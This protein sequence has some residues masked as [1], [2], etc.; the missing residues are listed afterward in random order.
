[1]QGEG[2]TIRGVQLLCL[3]CHLKDA[4]SAIDRAGIV[5]TYMASRD[6]ER[7]GKVAI[8]TS[9]L[10]DAV[11]KLMRDVYDEWDEHDEKEAFGR[12][13]RNAEE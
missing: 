9:S 5:A 1:M 12:E 4:L 2:V 6:P 11:S 3:L 13:G 8:G 7:D 10:R